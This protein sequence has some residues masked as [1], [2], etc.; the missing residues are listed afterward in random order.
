MTVGFEKLPINGGTDQQVASVVNLIVDGKI[1]A[2][3]SF[4]LIANQTTT[5]VTDLRAGSNS[6]INFTPT[7][8]NAAAALTTTFI[9]E[10]AKQSFTITHSNN[11]QTDKTYNYIIIA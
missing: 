5:V 2:F 3:G 6:I 10:R 7:T 1:N 8:S 11:S 4:T 9:S